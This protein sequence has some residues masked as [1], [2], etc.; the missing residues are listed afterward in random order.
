MKIPKKLKG[1]DKN[2]I[3]KMAEHADK[4]GNPLYPVPVLMDREKLTQMYYKVANWN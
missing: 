3:P 1:E 4:E 2:D